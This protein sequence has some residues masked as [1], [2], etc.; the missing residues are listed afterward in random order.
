MDI[1]Y[2]RKN[3]YGTIMYYIKDPVVYTA[4]KTLT[5]KMTVDE[6]DLRALQ[7]LGHTTTEVL[8]NS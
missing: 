4:I 5:K 7:M 8:Q 1:Q 3:V 2:I 6:R